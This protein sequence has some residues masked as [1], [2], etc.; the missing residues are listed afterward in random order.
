MLVGSTMLLWHNWDSWG[1]L[2]RL[3]SSGFPCAISPSGRLV[4]Y[5]SEKVGTLVCEHT[6][7]GEVTKVIAAREFRNLDF[8]GN[9]IQAAFSQNESQL[10]IWYGKGACVFDLKTHAITWIDG[11]GA[12]IAAISP[13]GDRL[14]TVAFGGGLTIWGTKTG[15]RLANADVT[16]EGLRALAFSPDGKKLAAVGHQPSV[17]LDGE[18][19]KEIARLE[20]WYDYEGRVKR[21]GTYPE[22][23]CWPNAYHIVSFSHDGKEVFCWGK[24]GHLHIFRYRKLTFGADNGHCISAEWDDGFPSCEMSAD[25]K[26][27]LAEGGIWRHR[28]PEYWWGLAWLPEFWLTVLFAGAF[29]WSVWRDRRVL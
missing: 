21:S 5:F 17:V 9:R 6:S 8:G 7:S 11:S 23:L 3:T 19:A 14:A 13:E 4:A 15:A 29:V 26:L 16:S 27:K 18:S 25:R 22:P 2:R 20:E 1:M 10:A 12:D 28:R 24:P